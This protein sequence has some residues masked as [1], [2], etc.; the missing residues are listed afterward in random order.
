M[1]RKCFRHTAFAILLA[2]SLTSTL[3]ARAQSERNAQQ[4]RRPASGDE[5]GRFQ[6]PPGGLMGRAAPGFDRLQTVLTEEQRASLREAM[7]GQ[8]EKL[9]DLEEQIRDQ[10]QQ[11]MLA[12]LTAKFDEEAVRKQA[13]AVAKVEAEMTVLRAKAFSQIR[14]A[15]SAEQIQKLKA[16]PAGTGPGSDQPETPRRRPDIPRDEHGLP[17]KDNSAQTKPQQ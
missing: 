16:A 10:R 7:Q 1:K 13:L 3:S 15:L 14:P 12:G 9:R 2:S 6:R 4:E 5:P 11:L 8:R 17:L